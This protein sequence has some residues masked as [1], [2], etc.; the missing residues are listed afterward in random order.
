MRTE[1]PPERMLR[2]GADRDCKKLAG[3]HN[4]QSQKGTHTGPEMS[5]TL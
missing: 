3:S 5:Q 1:K 2:G 4:R